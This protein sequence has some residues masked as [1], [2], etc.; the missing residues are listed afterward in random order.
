MKHIPAPA[1]RV[2]I[3]KINDKMRGLAIIYE[4]L[5]TEKTKMIS[6]RKIY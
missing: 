4:K 2:Y 3:P 6:F 1:K 5:A